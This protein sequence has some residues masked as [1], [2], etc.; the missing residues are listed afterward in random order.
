MKFFDALIAHQINGTITAARETL[1]ETGLTPDH[2]ESIIWVGGPTHYKPLRDKVAFELGIKGDT[3]SVNPMTAVAEGASIFAESIDWHSENKQTKATRGEMLS[4]ADLGLT[5]VYTAR[6]PSDTAKIATQM[7]REAAAGTEFQIDSYDTGWTSGRIPLEHS[8]TV[9]VSLTKPG[10]NT[11]KVTVYDAVGRQIPVDQ[12]EIVI[13]KTAAT[14]EGI[15]ASHSIALEVLDRLGGSSVPEYLI[16]KGDTIPEEGNI[17]LKAGE[18]LEAGS[19]HSLNFKLWEGEIENPIDDN[20][21]IGV[22]KIKG[23]DFDDGVIPVNADLKCNYEIPE[24][25]QIK[26]KVEV[27]SIGQIFDDVF[28]Y[29]DMTPD[30]SQ[31]VQ[32]GT[33][34][35][36]RIDEIKKLVD[37][38]K[39]QQ[40]EEKLKAATQLDPN[41]S[42][43]EKVLSANEDILSV[44][45]TAC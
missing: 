10:E 25:G 40:A 44:K 9:D 15:P 5:F 32:E 30:A 45:N 16:R 3:L 2:I 14:V 27:K 38:P 1:S 37:D 12:D 39:L 41:E 22:L 23:S 26:L 11:F 34:I 35:R 4:G 8:T 33:R 24:G 43:T 20:R 17:N 36:S 21:P 18:L 6:T 28:F 31:V 7:T 13:T 29:E 19:F 42:D